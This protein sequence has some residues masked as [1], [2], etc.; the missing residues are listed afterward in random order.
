MIIYYHANCTDAAAALAVLFIETDHFQIEYGINPDLPPAGIV[1]QP[2]H[3]NNEFVFPPEGEELMFV[4]YN[5]GVEILD[6][7]YETHKLTVIDHHEGDFYDRPYAKYSSKGTAACELMWRYCN[8]PA[9]GQNPIRGDKPKFINLINK[10]DTT[11]PTDCAITEGLYH[12][13]RNPTDGAYIYELTSQWARLR[14]MYVH[15]EEVFMDHCEF[16]G[17]GILAEQKA[18]KNHAIKTKFNLIIDGV[19]VTACITIPKYSSLVGGAL[20]EINKNGVGL[21]ISGSDSGGFGGAFR[22]VEG[23]AVTALEMAKKFEGGGH[24]SA[25]GCFLPFSVVGDLITNAV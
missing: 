3:P 21:A 7:L 12:E 13:L 6:K 25:A 18:V 11:G 14:H 1:L 19:E 20:A 9:K 2:M 24:K 15:N 4:D 16:I 8:D 10:R 17:K 5:P 22:S 23:A